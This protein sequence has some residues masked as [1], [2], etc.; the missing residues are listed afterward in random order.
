MET[1]ATVTARTDA[2]V[3]VA[4]EVWVALALLH[5][6]NPSR[7]SF[8]AG[9]IRQRVE[10]EGIAPELRPGVATHIGQHC[11]ANTPPKSGTYRMLLRLPDGSYRLYRPGDEC[12]PQ[13]KGKTTPHRSELPEPYRYLL[14]WYEREYRS[15]SGD[16]LIDPVLAMAGVGKDLWMEEGGDAFINRL[17]DEWVGEETSAT[18]PDDKAKTAPD[19]DRAW[20]RIIDHQGESFETV[21]GLPLTYEVEGAGI[22]FFRDGKRINRKLGRRQ[23]NMAIKRCPLENTVVIKDLFDYAYLFAVLMDKRIRQNDW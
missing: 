3:R 1:T 19:P 8:A 14:D 20:V 21:R 11:V 22:W 4:D 5:C 15:N 23:V 2:T 6:E 16:R 10:K 7:T 18:Q 13:R 12:H 9:E 17:R